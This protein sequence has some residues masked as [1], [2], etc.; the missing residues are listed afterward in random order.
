[1]KNLIFAT[2]VLF[3]SISFGGHDSAKG[4]A[5]SRNY[6]MAGCGLGSVIVGKRGGQIFAS[7]TNG[8]MSLYNNLFGMSSGTLN[9]VDGPTD[10]VAQNMDK[11]IIANKA[12]LA[13]EAAKGNGE[14]I[15]ALANIMGCQSSSTQVGQA[16]KSN[17]STIFANPAEHT[18]IITDGIIT[19]IMNDK[20]ASKNCHLEG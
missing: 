20:D 2:L 11:F 13:A 19:T 1:M 8:P 6:G 15:V 17:F 18:N 10:E 14:T 4:K 16:L 7:T 5:Y 3:S 12:I 9:C